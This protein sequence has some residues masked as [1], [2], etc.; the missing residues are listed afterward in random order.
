VNLLAADVGGTKTLLMVARHERGRLECRTLRRYES[1]AFPDFESMAERFLD[2]AGIGPGRLQGACLAV[3]GPVARREGGGQTAQLTNLPWE[4]DTERLAGR[5]GTPVVGLI[6]DFEGIAHSLDDLPESAL[7]TLQPGAPDP[8]GPRLV[9]G[10]GTGLGVCT[11]CPGHETLLPGE[12]GH[13]GFAPCDVQQ[14]R[15]WQFVTHDEGRCSREHLLSGRGIARIAAFLQTEGHAPGPAL[16]EALTE[17]DPAAALSRFA[18]RDDDPL[19]RETLRLFVRIFGAQAGDLA[20]AV[21]PTGGVYL[22]GGIA[23]RILP[24]LQNGDFMAAFV[25][26]APMGRLLTRFPVRVVTDPNAGLLGAARWAYRLAKG[27]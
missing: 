14:I 9:V 18:L 19:A 26:K 12:G 16:A 13:S 24:L 23:P 21:L 22:A 20:L 3:A 15:L 5:L 2:E 4:L 27:A 7:V 8:A 17:E 1:G 6:N 10:A 25:S 11:V